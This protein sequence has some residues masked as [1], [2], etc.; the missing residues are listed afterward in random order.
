L[1]LSEFS[2]VKPRTALPS[3]FSSVLTLNE[4]SERFLS[5]LTPARLE[6][7]AEQAA[8]HWVIER[9]G[10]VVAFLLAFREGTTYDSINYRWFGDR[11]RKF[12][13]IDRVVVSGAAKGQGF[14]TALYRTAFKH[15]EATAVQIVTCEFDVDPPNPVS[16]SFHVK[17]GF[18][19]VGRQLVAGGKKTVSL[20]AAFVDGHIGSPS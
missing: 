14:G 19:E 7:L 17:F 6:A 13:Y 8:A 10:S 9:E 11:Y 4:E 1:N 16:A 3:D 18:R 15:A 2:V 5:P 20:Q 12:L